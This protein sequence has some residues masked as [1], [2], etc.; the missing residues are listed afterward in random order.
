M[1][2]CP[3]STVS[4]PKGFFDA[5]LDSAVTKIV[6]KPRKTDL[7]TK[8]RK[9]EPF[10]TVQEVMND[11]LSTARGFPEADEKMGIKRNEDDSLVPTE[12]SKPTADTYKVRLGLA[13]GGGVWGVFTGFA[14]H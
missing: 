2:W 10:L 12:D 1:R 14:Q 7:G 9:S 6:K 11:A 13:L 8:L 5:N 4:V 3:R